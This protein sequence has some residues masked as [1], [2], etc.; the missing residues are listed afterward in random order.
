MIGGQVG[1]AER[2]MRETTAA[3]RA[4]WARRGR[5][6]VRHASGAVVFLALGFTGCGGHAAPAASVQ[7]GKVQNGVLNCIPWTATENAGAGIGPSAAASPDKTVE[8][9]GV[10]VHLMLANIDQCWRREAYRVSHAWALAPTND[11]LTST[12]DNIMPGEDALVQIEFWTPR[13]IGAFF[14]ENGKVNQI[15]REAFFGRSGTPGPVWPGPGVRLVLRGGENCTYYPS[16]LRP[17]GL[18]RDSIPTPQNSTPWTIQLFRSISR[19]FA[20]E[21]PRALHVL[22][23]WSVGERDIDDVD[24]VLG[25]SQGGNTVEG[26][27]RSAARGGP[28]AW[29]GS[30]QC[31]R[32]GRLTDGKPLAFYHGKCAKLIAHEVSHALGLHHVEGTANEGNLMFWLPTHQYMSETNKGVALTKEQKRE[33]LMEAREQFGP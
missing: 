15:L 11:A 6:V 25:G 14:G 9:I 12:V 26:Y 7:L 4:T 1:P 32:H 10:V 3:T 21:N 33:L 8:D 29:I 31:L 22:L 16:A 24:A 20:N 30:Y 2:V 13:M 28:A 27:S 17:D 18:L 5:R 23:W 19:L